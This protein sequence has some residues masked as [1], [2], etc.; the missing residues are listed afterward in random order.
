MDFDL[1]R[2]VNEME[3]KSY[4]LQDGV[5]LLVGKMFKHI[6]KLDDELQKLRFPTGKEGNPASS[7]LDIKL[8]N[9]ESRDGQFVQ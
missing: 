1:N 5:T 9:P 3:S 4:E 2:I 6:E 8:G 7:C